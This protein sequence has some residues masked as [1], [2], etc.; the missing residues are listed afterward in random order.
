[1]KC[2]DGLVFILA[3]H[4][5]LCKEILFTS[6]SC[7]LLFSDIQQLIKRKHFN[8]SLGYVY[9]NHRF[10]NYD[11]LSIFRWQLPNNVLF[12]DY[13]SWQTQSKR[14]L[15]KKTQPSLALLES[16]EQTRHEEVACE[17]SVS[18]FSRVPPKSMSLMHRCVSLASPS[19]GRGSE[20]C[21]KLLPSLSGFSGTA[22]L[23]GLGGIFQPFFLCKW[24]LGDFIVCLQSV[25]HSMVCN[26][27]GIHCLSNRKQR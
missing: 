18:C 27:F 16:R 14:F 6:L 25:F 11:G 21:C 20:F 15:Y 7:Y 5:S 2:S 23:E 26:D 19:T 10:N 9:E 12:W 17:P 24:S 1:M 22:E 13:N 8:F 4:L 3:S